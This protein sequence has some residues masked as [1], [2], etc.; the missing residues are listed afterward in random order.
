MTHIA[1]LEVDDEGNSA[2]RLEHVTDEQY[3]A[4]PEVSSTQRLHSFVNCWTWVASSIVYLGSI[5]VPQLPAFWG[6]SCYTAAK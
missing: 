3:R 6:Q 2:T 4:A 5:G 1:M